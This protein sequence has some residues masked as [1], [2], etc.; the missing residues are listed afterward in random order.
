MEKKRS[1]IKTLISE[2]DFEIA[3]LEIRSE[4]FAKKEAF[5]VELFLNLPN[6]NF[7]SYEDDH[8]IIEAFDLAMD[9]LIIQLRKYNEKLKS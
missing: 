9:K 2:N 8:T 6:E 7:I 1:R 5:K 3:R 4:K